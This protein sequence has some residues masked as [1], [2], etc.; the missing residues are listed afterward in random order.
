MAEKEV[1][2]VD[3]TGVVDT[4]KGETDVNEV[5]EESTGKPQGYVAPGP[6]TLGGSPPLDELRQQIA[7]T[8]SD[9]PLPGQEKDPMGRTYIP[10]LPQ[11]R[12]PEDADDGE[13][14]VVDETGYVDTVEGS[15]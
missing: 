7:E 1:Q 10:E 11:D 12:P 3:E 5:V 2:Q 15:S 13:I 6:E 14:T 9:G 4:V 8:W